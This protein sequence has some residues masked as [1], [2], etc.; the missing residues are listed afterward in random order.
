MSKPSR[1]QKC[2]CGH[3]RIRHDPNAGK[4]NEECS[5]KNFR[6]VKVRGIRLKDSTKKQ[7]V[8]GS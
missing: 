1:G 6:A 7:K 2:K 4:C 5:C 3:P 8:S